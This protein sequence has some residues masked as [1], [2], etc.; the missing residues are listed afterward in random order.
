MRL[1]HDFAAICERLQ[2]GGRASYG[3]PAEVLADMSHRL[4]G[5]RRA[6]SHNLEDRMTRV[7]DHAIGLDS[8]SDLM[9]V[10]PKLLE[11]AED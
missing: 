8:Q 2:A 7:T 5:L 3:L 1:R 9:A 6:V 4:R 10:L 11:E